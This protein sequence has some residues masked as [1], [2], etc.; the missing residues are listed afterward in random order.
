[1]SP[2]AIKFF[3]FGALIASL[4]IAGLYWYFGQPLTTIADSLEKH[5]I[6]GDRVLS[7]FQTYPL[8]AFNNDLT[9]TDTL[10]DG[11][12]IEFKNSA[13]S[14]LVNPEPER[15]LS[16]SFPESLSEP[17]SINL[18]GDRVITIINN[19]EESYRN[20]LLSGQP[21]ELD[22]FTEEGKTGLG[23]SDWEADSRWSDFTGN[24]SNGA[25]PQYIK[26]TSE[27]NRIETYYAY[28]KDQ[29]K[30]FRNLKHWTIFESGDGTEERSYS[31]TNAHL[32]VNDRGEAEVRYY[33]QAKAEQNQTVQTEVDSDLWARAQAVL[34][35]DL[36][37]TVDTNSPPD[38][39]IPAPYTIDSFGRL[40]T[41]EWEVSDDASTL[42]VFIKSGHHELP[43]CAR[44]NP[45][46]YCAWYKW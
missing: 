23:E 19:G 20:E 8:V 22:T 15:T 9:L 44:S 35:S 43:A 2:K 32:T 30:G 24:V 13:T 6:I 36:S 41:Y 37:S 5:P 27:D 31:F 42:T 10:K 1:M 34:G 7:D 14:T 21:P 11:I 4:F 39:T 16:L 38:F 45:A 26:Y 40:A 12:D 29:A 28:Q 33:D 25:I 46:I 3:S 18:G 17:M